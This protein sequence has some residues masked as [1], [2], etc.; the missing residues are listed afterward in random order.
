MFRLNH[1]A[2]KIIAAE[3]EKAAEKD[4]IA[5]EVAKKNC[6]AKIRKTTYSKRKTRYKNRIS[7]IN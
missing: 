6:S 5:G 1:K 7:R 3:I 4:P 2:Y